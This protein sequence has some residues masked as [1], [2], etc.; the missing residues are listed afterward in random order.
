MD[1]E[2]ELEHWM[3]WH[4]GCWVLLGLDLWLDLWLDLLLHSHLK[5][6]LVLVLILILHLGL[7]LLI[8]NWSL[9]TLFRKSLFLT[10][11]FLKSFL[12]SFLTSLIRMSLFLMSLFLMS[13]ILSLDLIL[14]SRFL[15]ILFLKSLSRI[16]IPS[17]G[18]EFGEVSRR[19]YSQTRKVVSYHSRLRC[20]KNFLQQELLSP[21]S[22]KGL[23]LPQLCL[24]SN[25]CGMAQHLGSTPQKELM[26]KTLVQTV[27]RLLDSSQRRSCWKTSSAQPRLKRSHLRSVSKSQIPAESHLR[28]LRS[29]RLEAPKLKMSDLHCLQAQ[30]VLARVYLTQIQLRSRSA[31]CSDLLAAMAK[32]ILRD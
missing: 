7:I 18:L 28:F 23:V 5:L 20:Q 32:V 2:T 19:L 15:M 16:L 29:P 14:M 17:L 31:V 6:I 21:R 12:K 26:W 9:M 10:G 27:Q 25:H 24:C 3:H 22:P 1:F 30:R 11:L 4:G 13:L 8:L